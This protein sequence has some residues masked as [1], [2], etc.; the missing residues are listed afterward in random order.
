MLTNAC[1][2][3]GRDIPCGPGA[4]GRCDDC[5]KKII[6]AAKSREAK[7]IEDAKPLVAENR[8]NATPALPCDNDPSVTTPLTHGTGG[9]QHVIRSTK[10]YT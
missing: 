10:R 6:D 8:A 3:C 9:G 7:A 5:H 1:F 2:D 4:G